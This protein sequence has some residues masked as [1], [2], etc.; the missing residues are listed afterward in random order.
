[1]WI[2]RIRFRAAQRL[3]VVC[4]KNKS[5]LFTQSSSITSFSYVISDS[6]W[7]LLNWLRSLWCDW[8]FSVWS[9]LL[10]WSLLGYDWSCDT[11]DDLV[12]SCNSWV[13]YWDANWN[14]GACRSLSV[15]FRFV[16]SAVK[17]GVQLISN[18]LTSTTNWPWIGVIGITAA[19]SKLLSGWNQAISHWNAISF[20]EFCQFDWCFWDPSNGV[21]VFDCCAV[22]GCGA[23]WW[24]NWHSLILKNNWWSWIV[25]L[26]L[27]VWLLRWLVWSLSGWNDAWW[28]CGRSL[29]CWCGAVSWGGLNRSLWNTALGVVS[30]V[31][32]TVWAWKLFTTLTSKVQKVSLNL[33]PFPPGT[34]QQSG[35]DPPLVQQ[36]RPRPPLVQQS[37]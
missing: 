28:L 12:G 4:S 36:S 37:G 23:G 6:T 16:C 35:P 22:H 8:N 2:L 15:A 5:N 13:C 27:V 18:V 1:M 21:A 26:W 7:L 24:N 31:R 33:K 10:R 14:L 25:G 11:C 20:L 3:V 17:N 9:W 32:A 29:S 34:V 19:L 30:A